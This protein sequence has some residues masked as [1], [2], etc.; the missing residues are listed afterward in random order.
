MIGKLKAE[1]EQFFSGRE[2][3]F[4]NKYSY[5]QCISHP[6]LDSCF[7]T[8]HSVSDLKGV[9]E[10]SMSSGSITSESI[11]NEDEQKD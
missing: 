6:K 9:N 3:K 1:K 8:V 7:L 10:D 2:I 5:L 11:D 4:M